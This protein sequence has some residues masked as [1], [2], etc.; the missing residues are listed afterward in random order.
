MS[1]KHFHELIFDAF[2]GVHKVRIR[3]FDNNQNY[4]LHLIVEIKKNQKNLRINK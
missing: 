1:A 3:P 4:I 2:L